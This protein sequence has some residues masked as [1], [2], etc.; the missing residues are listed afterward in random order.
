MKDQVVI[1]TNE[2]KR[3]L[4]DINETHGFQSINVNG[5]SYDVNTKRSPSN[6]H[7]TATLLMYI[8][9]YIKQLIDDLVEQCLKRG[10][11][12]ENCKLISQ[13]PYV[14]QEIEYNSGFYGINKPKG[15]IRSPTKKK[16]FHLDNDYRATYRLIMLDLR[17]ADGSFVEWDGD[18]DHTIKGTLIHELSHT[19]CN[20]ITYRTKGNHQKDFHDCERV[21]LELARVKDPARCKSPE[22]ALRVARSPSPELSQIEDIITNMIG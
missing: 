9:L 4:W 15:I 19:M 8:D 17:R 21:L 20:H 2:K 7:K 12:S 22:G 5:K 11:L 10:V 3:H 1:E 13:T 16:L 6:L 18:H 14:V